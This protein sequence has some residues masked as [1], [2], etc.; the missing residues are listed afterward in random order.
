[1]NDEEMDEMF[2]PQVGFDS[3]SICGLWW[4]RMLVFLC[5]QFCDFVWFSN[6]LC[7]R[8]LQLVAFPLEFGFERLIA[9]RYGGMRER[10]QGRS[11]GTF[12]PGAAC[13]LCLNC[14][15]LV[16]AYQ[17]W[18]G[19]EDRRAD[20]CLSLFLRIGPSWRLHRA[21]GCRQYKIVTPLFILWPMYRK[22][23]FTLLRVTPTPPVFA[24]TTVRSSPPAFAV[25]TLQDLTSMCTRSP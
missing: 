11:V 17:L 3:K 24:F 8:I 20:E 22:V 21:A 14:R 5:C 16:L 7:V 9:C 6:F 13:V 15:R 18:A 2:A 25:T 1:M 23:G 4:H 12:S 19:D 10:R